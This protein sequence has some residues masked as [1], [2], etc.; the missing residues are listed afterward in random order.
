MANRALLGLA[1]IGLA[2]TALGILNDSRQRQQVR[3]APPVDA[4]RHRLDLPEG[5]VTIFERGTGETVLLVHSFNIAG[6]SYEMKPFFEHLSKTR[7][8]IAFDWLGFGT[9]D[10][11][12]LEYNTPLFRRVLRQVI[13]RFAGGRIDVIALGLPAQYVVMEALAQPERFGKLVLI[14]PA[15]FG[16]YSAEGGQPTPRVRA[17]DFVLPLP[18]AGQSLF[19]AFAS[20]RSITHALAGLFADDSRLG[21]DL[22][23]YCYRSANQPGAIYAARSVISGTLNDP[24]AEG[25]YPRLTTPALMLAGEEARLTDLDAARQLASRNAHVSLQVI[26]DCGG[27][28]QF[29]QPEETLRLTQAFLA[30]AAGRPQPSAPAVSA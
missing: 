25:A 3:L 9:S 22:V 8:V 13:D 1:G 2:G 16:K 29:E 12:N 23:T 14:S 28:P 7:R 5:T 11:P 26:A 17:I 4:T 20:R 24:A 19:N 21:N 18:L 10:R 27:L 6:S 15:G 30:G